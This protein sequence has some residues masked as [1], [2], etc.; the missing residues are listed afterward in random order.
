[1][2]DEPRAHTRTGDPQTSFAA[3]RAVDP[4]LTEI[5]RRV[6]AFAESK[7]HY[8]FT[9]LELTEELEDSTSTLRSRRAELA[10]RNIL[11]N[12]HRTRQSGTTHRRIVWIHRRFA[13]SPPPIKD[14][15]PR[16][17]REG[18]RAGERRRRVAIAIATALWGPEMAAHYFDVRYDRSPDVRRG[19]ALAAAEAA[20]A[21]M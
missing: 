11:I 5:Q 3:A 19:Q 13:A 21:A 7:G 1:M 4:K 6:I 15:P 18:V 12:S 9:D 10:D 20:I 17:K 2:A 8:G 16:K 14:P